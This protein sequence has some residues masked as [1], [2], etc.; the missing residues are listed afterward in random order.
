AYVEKEITVVTDQEVAKNLKTTNGL[1]MRKWKVSLYSSEGGEKFPLNFVDKVEYLLHPTFENPER[2]VR[3]P[4]FVLSE[5]GWGEFDMKIILHFID[6]SIKPWT[7]EHDLNF[8]KPHY[9]KFFD[10]KPSFLKLLFQETTP[11]SQSPLKTKLGRSKRPKSSPSVSTKRPKTD[12][13][14]TPT[15]NNSP[16]STSSSYSSNESMSNK[17]NFQVDYNKL[18]KNLYELEGDDILEV[19][20][21]VKE[22]QTSEMYINEETEGEFHLDLHTLGDNLLRVLW[23]FTESKLSRSTFN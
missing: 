1:P 22:H 18:A 12:L 11:D 7:L 4:P 19:I 5:K 8:Q 21:L 14:V 13:P 20:H 9:E 17:E 3:K 6:K 2:V 16:E 10:P 15:Y 23:D